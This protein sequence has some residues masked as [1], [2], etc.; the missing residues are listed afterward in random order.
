MVTLRGRCGGGRTFSTL[1]HRLLSRHCFD[2]TER[3]F[4]HPHL[5][6]RPGFVQ[7]FNASQGSVEGR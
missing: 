2:V 4:M 3:A 7:T 5:W 1:L 6:E